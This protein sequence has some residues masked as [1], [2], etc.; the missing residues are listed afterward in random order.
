MIIIEAEKKDKK[1]EVFDKVSAL[2]RSGIS[3]V[4][5]TIK[6]YKNEKKRE[7]EI[8]KNAVEKRMLKKKIEFAVKKEEDKLERK[9]N[10]KL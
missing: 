7:H 8:I 6:E 4:G 9:I 3:K 1:R 10:F 2:F 5:Q